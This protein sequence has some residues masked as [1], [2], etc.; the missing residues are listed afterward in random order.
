MEMVLPKDVP[1][2]RAKGTKNLTRPDNVFC[3]DGAPP[4]HKGTKGD[5]A[6]QI[7]SFL[8][9]DEADYVD[10]V[11][12]QVYSIHSAMSLPERRIDAPR[13]GHPHLVLVGLLLQ[14]SRLLT[15]PVPP[16]RPPM[17]RT[18]KRCVIV[19]STHRH[20]NVLP[21]SVGTT[22]QPSKVNHLFE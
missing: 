12:S 15:P 2:L 3:S 20:G 5:G 17:Q 11:S 7:L 21:K 18:A 13:R 4:G 14:S 1:T 19:G 10:L 6:I 22:S 16:Q 9:N 8:Q